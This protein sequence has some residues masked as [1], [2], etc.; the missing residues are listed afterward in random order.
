MLSVAASKLTRGMIN[1][2]QMSY[3][4]EELLLEIPQKLLAPNLNVNVWRGAN[5]YSSPCVAA[6][7]QL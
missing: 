3:I 7:G 2:L 4:G 6:F 1:L 5:M